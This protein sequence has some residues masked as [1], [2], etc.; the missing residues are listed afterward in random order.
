MYI[1]IHIYIY[2][3]IYIQHIYTYIYTYIHI[4]IQYTNCFYEDNKFYIWLPV[5]PDLLL[6][7]PIMT[8]AK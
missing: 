7:M 4:H 2:I 1:Y 3:Y 6:T 5:K 8:N